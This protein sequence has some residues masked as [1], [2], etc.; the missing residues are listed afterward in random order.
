[1]KKLGNNKYF[2][3]T[4]NIWIDGCRPN[5][6]DPVRAA[7]A[8]D[9]RKSK[10]NRNCH[11]ATSKAS[12]IAFQS[13]TIYH[14]EFCCNSF[15]LICFIQI[16]FSNLFVRVLFCFAADHK[17]SFVWSVG[18]KLGLFSPTSFLVPISANRK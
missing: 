5:A 16:L 1:M 9:Q 6:G 18:R 4:I 12:T 17:S 10:L 15:M 13:L 2:S 7:R 11:N 14:Q 3:F 8:V